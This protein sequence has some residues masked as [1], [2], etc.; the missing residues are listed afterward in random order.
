MFS[1]LV[2]A[3]TLSTQPVV[4]S[5]VT[6]QCEYLR[7][8]SAAVWSALDD[9]ERVGASNLVTNNLEMTLRAIVQRER[10]ACRV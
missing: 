9:A 7:Y 6:P 4:P 8:M 5:R 2:L 1:A 10:K 3:A